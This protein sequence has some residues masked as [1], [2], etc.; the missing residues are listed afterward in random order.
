M[1]RQLLKQ[2]QRASAKR[3]SRARERRERDRGETA[4]TSRAAALTDAASR[5]LTAQT[6]A[7][8]P[9]GQVL[10]RQHG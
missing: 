7:T 10:S 6:L 8:K 4:A 3:A 9:W 5:L 2:R 1:R